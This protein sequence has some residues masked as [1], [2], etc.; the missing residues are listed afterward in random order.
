MHKPVIVIVGAGNMGSSL[1]L[2]LLKNGFASKQIWAVDTNEQNLN[3]LK[4]AHGIQIANDATLTVAFADAVILAVKPQ[5]LK[6]AAQALG[7]TLQTCAPLLLSIAAGINIKNL[8]AWLGHQNAIVRAMPN[9]PALLGCGATALF[10]NHAVTP[11]QRELAELIFKSVG[12]TAWVSEESM[13]DTVT[14]LSGSG[15]AYFFLMMQ[16]LQKSAESLGL[17]P[18]LSHQFTVQTAFG[19]AKMALEKN[20]SLEHLK[21]QVTSPKGTTEKGLAVLNEADLFSIM[22]NTLVAAKTR[23]EELALENE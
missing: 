23:A 21:Q 9:T 3:K 17:S 7:A 12:I 8:A 22:H 16:A 13:L 19:A 2:G 6:A 5:S 15:P 11:A 1:I 4:R 10:A 18:E 14:A 20:A